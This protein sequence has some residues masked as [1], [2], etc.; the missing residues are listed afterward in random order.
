MKI[1][2]KGL[3]IDRLKEKLGCCILYFRELF[4]FKQLFNKEYSLNR[5]TPRKQSVLSRF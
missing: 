4:I 2:K 5:K 3:K 1:W